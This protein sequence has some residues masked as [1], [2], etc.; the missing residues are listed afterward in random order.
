MKVYIGFDLGTTNTKALVVTCEGKIIEVLKKKTSSK[1]ISDIEYFDILAVE[2]TI[3]EMLSSLKKKYQVA[4]ISFT[5]IGESVIPVKNGKLLYLPLMWH[6]TIT[7]DIA[8]SVEKE[9]KKL[10]S[11]ELTGVTND[12]RLSLYKILWMQ[13]HLGI[14]DVDFWLPISSYMAY[15]Y[16]GDAIWAESQACRSYFFNIHTREWNNKILKFAEIE[17]KTGTI[18]YTGTLAGF[19]KGIPVGV[20]GHDHITGLYGIYALSGEESGIF[21]DSMGTSSVLASIVEEKDKE[22]HL[23]KPFFNGSTGSLGA[24]FADR[25]YYIQNSF[26]Y[27]GILL[28]K[29]MLIT[30]G[31]PNKAYYDAFNDS[32]KKLPS[33]IPKAMFSIGGDCILGA[34]K[35]K[36]NILNFPISISAIEIMQSAYI[37][38]CA[39]TR[40]ILE[41]LFKYTKDGPYF[42]GGGIVSNETFMRYKASMLKRDITIYDTEELT[43][44]GAAIAA[45]VSANDKDALEA[46]RMNL[47]KRK[48]SPDE[49]IAMDLDLAYAHYCE[50]NSSNIIDYFE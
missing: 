40:M 7:K 34:K 48:I 25:H 27:F 13:R 24:A 42:A 22:L 28:E 23:K 31:L 37:Y 35:N 29:I 38:L 18:A 39:M 5:S 41:G 11:Y 36:V 4:G 9:I 10:T 43:A 6:E 26:R 30:G 50:L 44:L 32:I 33:A 21:Y 16:T 2:K 1:R 20:A 47:Q 46:C 49:K 15:R 12:F 8:E 17:G 14:E 19:Y 45:I 3:N